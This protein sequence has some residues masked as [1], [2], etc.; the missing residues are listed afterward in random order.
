MALDGGEV[1]QVW[2]KVVIEEHHDIHVPGS[3]NHRIAL[4]GRPGSASSSL[5]P[6]LAS[7]AVLDIG[8]LRAARGHR[9]RRPRLQPEFVRRLPQHGNPSDDWDADCNPAS[10]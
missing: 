8:S 7:S 4:L 3:R 9:V 6:G 2:Q 1:G 5:T 10:H